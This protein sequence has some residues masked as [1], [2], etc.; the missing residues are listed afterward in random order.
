MK[1]DEQKL[2]IIDSVTSDEVSLWH[3]ES[4]KRLIEELKIKM[5]TWDIK[6]K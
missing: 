4:D 1:S 2:K 5:I 6:E 3:S